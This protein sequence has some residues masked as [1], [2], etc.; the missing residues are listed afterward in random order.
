MRGGF[1]EDLT[2]MDVLPMFLV[3]R[4]RLPTGERGAN[5]AMDGAGKD[6]LLG[7]SLPRLTLIGVDGRDKSPRQK[8]RRIV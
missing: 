7:G 6:P 1:L 8:L 4:H 3:L 2:Q 5:D